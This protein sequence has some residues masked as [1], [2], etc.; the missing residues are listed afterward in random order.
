MLLLN[1][2]GFLAVVFLAVVTVRR[3]CRA[4]PTP[5][6]TTQKGAPSFDRIY[7]SILDTTRVVGK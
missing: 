4:L 5:L 1:Q 7:L 2:C 6:Y 3:R